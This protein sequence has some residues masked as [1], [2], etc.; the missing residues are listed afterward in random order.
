LRADRLLSL[1][2]LLQGKGK[3]KARELARR[4][5][6]SERT[7]YRDLDALSAAG[8]PVFADRGP[9]GGAALVAGW[10]TSVAGLTDAEAQ[11]LAIAGVPRALSQLGLSEPLKTGLIKLAASLPALQQRAAEE[12]RQRLLIDVKPWFEPDEAVPHLGLLRDAVWRGRKVRLEYGD[13]DGKLTQRSVDPYA[14]VVKLD[15][16]YLV[17]GTPRGPTV[18]RVSRIQQARLLGQGFERPA[19]FDLEAFW[20]EW[21]RRFAERRSS[22]PVRL[23]L[24][25]AGAEALASSRPKADAERIARARRGSDGRLCVT[26]D[27]EKQAIAVAQ[28]VGRAPSVEAMEPPELRARLAEIAEALSCYRPPRQPDGSSEA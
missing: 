2:L 19:A 26:L 21:C 18:F 9:H 15:R 13:F 10:R 28:L 27:F 14:L 25:D 4:L 7:V 5:E 20:N 17:A 22:Y 11:A 8:V 3:T 6:V 23:A 1:L 24:T 16:L 12:A